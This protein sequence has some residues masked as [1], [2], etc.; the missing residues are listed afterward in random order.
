M[1][2]DTK[3]LK[4]VKRPSAAER[5]A[6]APRSA[7][8]ES[9]KATVDR[10]PEMPQPVTPRPKP[11]PAPLAKPAKQQQAQQQVE[12]KLLLEMYRTMYLSRKIDDKEIQLKG[13]NKIFFQISGAG[14]EAILVAAGMAMRPGYD[15]FYP[16]YR[17]RA[18]CLQLGMTPYEQL[19]SAVGAADDP[20]S[21]GRQMPS[22]WGN[23]KL[24]IVAQSSPTGTQLLQ[25]VGCAEASYRL[26]LIPEL[27][28]RIKGF[29]DDEVT[30]VSLGDGTSS[31]G[32]FWEALNTACNL[33]LPVLFL[34]E[35]NGYAISV[36][37]EVQTAGGDVSR[38]VENFP[39]LYLQ[40]CDGT[41]V[42]ESLQ[43]MQRAA[44][45]CRQRKGPAFVHAKVIRPYSHSLSDDERL[46]RP[47][48][49]RAGDAER[50]PVKRFGGLLVD[51]GVIDQVGLQQI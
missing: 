35:D 29:H 40:R 28:Q 45:Y 1:K 27:K 46:Y 39:N 22:H 49:E 41:D 47:D 10:P 24:N 3:V 33:K 11:R 51:E 17:D 4:L 50:D 48:E 2:T 30:Y 12:P 36:P 7:E 15:W 20:N 9:S 14:H 25:A 18:L 31:E 6:E 19:L 26:N 23:K 8:V 44:D 38:L 32:E 34:L 43:T 16:Y 21:H 37:V 5:S 13:Q 42:I